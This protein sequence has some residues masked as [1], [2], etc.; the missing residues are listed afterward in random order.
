[1]YF[2]CGGE[3]YSIVRTSWG[4]EQFVPDHDK[5]RDYIK[6]LMVHPGGWPLV[7]SL[8]MRDGVEIAA[9]VIGFFTGA[10]RDA[11][12]EPATSSSST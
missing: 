4:E 9:A 3:P 2:A 12:P 8:P 7:A 11:S 10:G 5:V 6:T 1:N